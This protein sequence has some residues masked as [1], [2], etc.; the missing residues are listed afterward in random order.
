VEHRFRAWVQRLARPVA[1]R[2]LAIGQ[3]HIE[4]RLRAGDGRGGAGRASTGDQD[5][6]IE[7]SR[8]YGP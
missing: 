5:V 3:D 2:W 8:T 7:A 4:A 1:W 6:G